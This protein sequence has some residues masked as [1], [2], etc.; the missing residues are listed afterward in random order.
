MRQGGER[1][2]KNTYITIIP[3]QMKNFDKK[4]FRSAD[5]CEIAYKGTKRYFPIT[6]VIEQTQEEGIGTKVVAVRFRTEVSDEYLDLLKKELSTIETKDLEIVEVTVPENQEYHNLVD[7][8]MK[9]L[10]KIDDDTDVYACITFGTKIM[11]LI[12]AY[13]L[14]SLAYIRNNAKVQ[15]VYYLELIRKQGE[16]VDSILYNVTSLVYLNKTVKEIAELNLTDPQGFLMQL[17]KKNEE[18]E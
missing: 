8:F 7:V 13:L 6:S 9:V 4:E 17:L 15:G 5:G 12:I 1:I 14:D 18:L 10:G 11:S 3:M 2:L 16:V